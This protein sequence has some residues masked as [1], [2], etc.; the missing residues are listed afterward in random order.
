MIR[1]RLVVGIRDMALSEKLQLDAELTLE[2]A[3]KAIRQREAV[4]EHQDVLTGDLRNPPT[5]VDAIQHTKQSRKTS[6]KRLGG[7]SPPKKCTRCGK[8]SHM[9]DKCPARD[10][11]CH[12]CQHKGHYS[13]QCFTKSAVATVTTQEL[14]NGSPIYLDTIGT[15]TPTNWMVTSKILGKAITFK[16][17]TGAAVTAISKECHEILGKPELQKPSKSLQGPD[18]QSLKVVG[19]FEETISHKGKSCKQLYNLSQML[20]LRL[21]IQQGRYH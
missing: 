6:N 10:A 8:G 12:K 5:A 11:I 19:Q 3:K 16:V 1:D 15:D 7:A 21:Y 9:K 18:D 20:S 2:K 17:D 14:G 4:H 13:S